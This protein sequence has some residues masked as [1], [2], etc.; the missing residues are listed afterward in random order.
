MRKLFCAFALVTAACLQVSAGAPATA[1]GWCISADNPSADGYSPAAVANG[2]ISL[3][4]SPELFTNST[5]ILSGTFD[6][7]DDQDCIRLLDGYNLLNCR[8]WLGGKELNRTNVSDFTQ[9]LDMKDSRFCCSFTC[10]DADVEYAYVA[11]GGKPHVVMMTVTV[12]PKRDVEMR[13]ENVRQTP[14]GFTPM[15]ERIDSTRFR[16][17]AV[18]SATCRSNMGRVQLGSAAAFH[19]EGKGPHV[20][21]AA[22]ENGVQTLTFS[23]S[24]KKGEKFTFALMGAE[25]QSLET[26]TPEVSAQRQLYDAM[27]VGVSRLMDSHKAYWADLWRG[28]IQIDGNVKDQQDVRR[29]I[30]SIYSSVRPGM[31]TSPSPFGLSS[32]GYSGHVF[33]DTEI[34][35][36]PPMLVLNP[37]I[38]RSMMDYRFERLEAARRNAAATGSDGARYPWESAD[39]GDEQTPAWADTGYQEI[40]VTADVAIAAWNYY[41]V[42][43]DIEWLRAKG[44]PMILAAADYYASRAVKEKDGRY[45]ILNVVG[46]D[47]YASNVD[48]NAYTNGAAKKNLEIA[49]FAAKEVGRIPD[50]KWA[51]V[52]DGMAFH[53]RD[54][55]T[56]VYRDYNGDTTKQADVV[57]LAYPLGLITDP[58]QIKRDLTY[59]QGKVPP[60]GVP[61]M[62]EAIYSVL[63]SKLGMP[64]KAAAFFRESYVKNQ[65]GP[66][67]GISECKGGK[68]P[69]F[70]TGAGGALQAVI[71]GYAGYEI[72]PEGL[73]KHPTRTLPPEWK[74][75]KV[76]R[77]E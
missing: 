12:D 64:E 19:F 63:Y 75:L 10:A 35:M 77:V 11:L 61:A 39:D 20:I 30:Y 48:D 22:P 27:R 34:W 49:V 32:T 15:G 76:I 67:R 1:E 47:E 66:F 29:M 52:A 43:R 55:V 62:T 40:H 16:G 7:A 71:M 59:Y 28:D 50:P 57:L 37:K 70:A 42:T 73:V 14:A 18:I 41:L 24:L 46:A 6:R 54:G 58:E 36:Y 44:A 13:V 53:T 26:S 9:T 74:S 5:S 17:N 3:V 56:L 21:G 51:E 4:S 25:Y 65:H 45:H 33:W 8:M 68:L 23:M 2:V 38:A 72:T 69:Y 31:A 60:S